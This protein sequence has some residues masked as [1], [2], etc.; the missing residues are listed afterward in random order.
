M[1]RYRKK[2]VIV[3]AKQWFKEGDHK[4]VEAIPEALTFFIPPKEGATGYLSEDG[5]GYFVKPGDWIIKGLEGDYYPCSPEVF[6]ATYE[7]VE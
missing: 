3:E 7:E 5:G 2:P 1:K 6:E 4:A